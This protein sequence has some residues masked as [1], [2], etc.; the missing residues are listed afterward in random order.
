MN[1]KEKITASNIAFMEKFNFL[2][3]MNT[4]DNAK[5]L[6]SLNDEMDN[7]FILKKIFSNEYHHF[8]IALYINVLNYYFSNH[9][10]LINNIKNNC[11]NPYH[12]C[13]NFKGSLYSY[14]DYFYP[15]EKKNSNKFNSNL[16]EYLANN[17]LIFFQIN[18]IKNT[19][20]NYN[21]DKILK[22][23]KHLILFFFNVKI[24]SIN[25]KCFGEYVDLIKFFINNFTYCCEYFLEEFCIYNILVEYLVNCPL[26][27]IK[28]V[29]VGLINCAMIN[30]MEKFYIKQKKDEK[31]KITVS[32]QKK[33]VA[34][35]LGSFKGSSKKKDLNF[36]D[37]IGSKT[38]NKSALNKTTEKAEKKGENPYRK[39]LEE[40]SE[41]KTLKS[42]NADEKE[43]EEEEEKEYC[44]KIMV[45]FINNVIALINEIGT[46]NVFDNKFLYYVLYKFSIISSN[47]REYLIKVIPVLDFLNIN[48]NQYLLSSNKNKINKETLENIDIKK[49]YD[50]SFMHDILN[51]NS[52]HGKIKIIND[53]G[54]IYHYE[55]YLYLLYFNLLSDEYKDKEK[56]NIFSFDN[57]DFVFKL[58]TSLINR[59]DCF[60]FAHLIN[61]KCYNNLSRE[62]LVINLIFDIL[63][64]LDYKEDINYKLNK[65]NSNTKITTIKDYKNRYEL[66]PRNILL[67]LRLFILNTDNDGNIKKN[68]IKISI[69]KLFELIK[70]HS[71]YYNYC[72][73][74]IDFIIDLYLLNEIMIKEYVKPFKEELEYIKNWIK[75]RPISP[76]LYKIEGLFMYRDD[77]VNYQQNITEQQK[78]EFDEK[79][80]IISNKKINLLNNIIKNNITGKDHLFDNNSVNMSEFLFTKNDQVIFDGKSA[81]VT[82]HLNEM[83][84]IK[85]DQKVNIKEIKKANELHNENNDKN[86]EEENK[87]I[88]K[89]W[90][91]IEDEKLKINRLF[92]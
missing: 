74:L 34:E 53:K 17:K 15:R 84:K 39:K 8:L 70:K 80:T 31:I 1:S 28:K 7:Y 30:M 16:Y 23:F 35:I 57:S 29:I 61:A 81:V 63:D 5:L 38:D 77:N 14:K 4:P 44:P 82:E 36:Y 71:K 56:D 64:K 55:N 66:D 19:D 78:K 79:E 50:Y 67:T 10:I 45:Q 65:A 26:Y 43:E 3:K 54:G 90:V 88:S 75:E 52:I 33:E 68:R 49:Y 58:F 20:E 46:N 91:D 85:F 73:L 40:I 37:V 18:D 11:G 27:E 87:I 9:N 89:I 69:Q 92:I 22:L 59:Q 60:L 12:F 6:K 32:K 62:N 76:K 42:Q 86:S 83:I 25:K 41:L 47:T 72:I 51:I 48:L 2:K 24:R 13:L 21:K